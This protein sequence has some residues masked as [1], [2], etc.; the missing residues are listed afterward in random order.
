M[1]VTKLKNP[2]EHKGR[3]DWED[4]GCIISDACLRCPLPI[5]KHDD[6]AWYEKYI[7]LS[8]HRHAIMELKDSMANG[9]VTGKIMEISEKYK[10][11][12]RTMWRLKKK[13]EQEEIDY[14]MIELF[15]KRVHKRVYGR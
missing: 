15:Y 10:V 8:K 14:D 13:L 11:T 1:V 6:K 5:C 12:P 9:K 3:S 4:T 2:N 7:K